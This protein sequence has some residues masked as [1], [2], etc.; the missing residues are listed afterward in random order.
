MIWS[1]ERG[2]V[3]TPAIGIVACL[4]RKSFSRCAVINLLWLWYGDEASK[5]CKVPS[6]PNTIRFALTRNR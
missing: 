2:A 4:K 3:G 1:R 5:E 6:L